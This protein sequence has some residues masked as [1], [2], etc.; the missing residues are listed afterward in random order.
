MKPWY[1]SRDDAWFVTLRL[2]DGSRRQQK[3]C[4]GGA[5]EAEA[6]VQ[7]SRYQKGQIKAPARLTVADAFDA[8]LDW[9]HREKKSATFEH[10]RY[11]LQSFADTGVKQ[12]PV[13]DLIP[14]HLTKWL[15]AN[16]W[17][18]TSRNR[19]ISCV[20][21]ALSWCVQEGLIPDSPLK[22]VRKDRMLRRETTVSPEEAAKI[23]AE[24]KDQA[25]RLYLFAMGQTGA[26][27]MEVRTVTAADVRDGEWVMKS[28]DFAVTAKYR[29]IYLTSKMVVLTTALCEKY[30]EGPLFRNTRGLPWTHNAI[31][32][33][34]RNLRRKLGLPKGIV[35]TAMRHTWVTDALEAGIP[36][37]TVSELA[38]HR[39]TKMVEQVY[40]KLSERKAHL[41]A[42]AQKAVKKA[43]GNSTPGVT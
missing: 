21:R 22:A 12:K 3:L 31:R 18:S 42:A 40:S 23:N 39:S 6:W 5:N 34:F 19:A 17:N 1:R 2:P 24:V 37:A 4:D 10:Y 30:P 33:R 38:G 11:F 25:F 32:I 43:G 35:A 26:R 28:K 20:K 7:L 16:D 14:H 9:A 41:R 15:Q 29:H 36:I 8:F 27:S 13:S